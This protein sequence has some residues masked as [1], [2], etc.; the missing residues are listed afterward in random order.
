MGWIFLILGVSILLVTAP[1]LVRE[2]P[3]GLEKAVL[4]LQN[5]LDT[6]D[7]NGETSRQ[8]GGFNANSELEEQLAAVADTLNLLQKRLDRWDETVK[9]LAK[10]SE[11]TFENTLSDVNQMTLFDDIYAAFDQGKSVTE[12]AREYNRGKGE[13]ELILS[14]RKQNNG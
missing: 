10:Q 1:G 6:L 12:I 9:K 4:S 14:L 3:A 7:R 2:K 13:I 5:R 11:L 8:V